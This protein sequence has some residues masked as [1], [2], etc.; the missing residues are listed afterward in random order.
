MVERVKCVA[1]IPLFYGGGSNPQSEP[2]FSASRRRRIEGRPRN[3]FPSG[4]K[5]ERK[6]CRSDLDG[7]RAGL[8]A[9]Y[10]KDG[11][12]KIDGAEVD[13]LKKDFAAGK[14]EVK[15]LDTN[16][17]GT[18]SDEEIAAVGGKHKKKKNK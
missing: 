8:L 1:R 14:P 12:G 16:T 11:S 2:A 13:A 18:L 10:D 4:H 9:T 17:D 7:Y 5:S 15:G 3:S 6:R